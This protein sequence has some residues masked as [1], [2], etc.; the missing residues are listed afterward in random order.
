MTDKETLYEALKRNELRSS[1]Q[2]IWLSIHLVRLHWKTLIPAVLI[3]NGPL[4]FL[5]LYLVTEFWNKS[6][7][8][9]YG[10]NPISFTSGFM[11]AMSFG[12]C[13][14]AQNGLICAFVRLC[15]LGEPLKIGALLRMTLES[16]PRQVGWLFLTGLSSLI[17]GS[18]F[19][20]IVAIVFSLSAMLYALHLTFLIPAVLLIFYLG[21]WLMIGFIVTLMQL[22]FITS[23]F[24]KRQIF[25][26]FE[27][28]FELMFQ[29][30]WSFKQG[31]SLGFSVILLYIV[32]M[33][34]PSLLYGILVGTGELFSQEMQRFLTGDIGIQLFLLISVLV[35]PVAA[36]LP[37]M[38]NVVGYFSM[39]EANR[40]P[41]LMERIGQVG[42][43]KDVN[44][45]EAEFGE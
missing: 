26:G 38:T 7:F 40:A 31:L 29:S 42:E 4:L 22:M 18:C 14:G 37:V 44:I 11:L 1:S 12:L 41:A 13:L 5:V 45:T 23:Y 28:A 2:T 10:T 3:V 34:V 30:G 25:V 19:A 16:I 27:R 35:Y 39:Y 20:I 33:G 43:L 9:F 15:R 17:Y 6:Y 8:S 36:I 32:V 24:E 21:F